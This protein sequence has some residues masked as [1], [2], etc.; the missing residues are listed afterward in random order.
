MCTS[1]YKY[2][3]GNAPLIMLDLNEWFGG[4]QCPS[5]HMQCKHHWIPP[6]E[7]VALYPWLQPPRQ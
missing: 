1:I 4:D 2:V 7:V 3:P 5:T 6:F